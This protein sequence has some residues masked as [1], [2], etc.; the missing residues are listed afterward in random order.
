MRFPRCVSKAVQAAAPHARGILRAGRGEPSGGFATEWVAL[1]IMY[2]FLTTTLLQ[3]YVVPTGSMEGNLRVGDHLLVDRAA[4]QSPGSFGSGM[5]PYRDV[6]RG[7]IIV[8][9]YPEDV[10]KTYVKR[11][12]GLP[13]DRIRIENKQVI[14]NG[15]RLV[16]PYT[17]HID[18]W[19]NAYRDNFPQAPD[20]ETSPRGL[21]MLEHHVRNGEVVLPAGAL[22]ALGDNRDNSEDSRYWGFVPRENVVGKPLIVYWSYDAP[23]EDLQ[24][25]TLTHAVD[26]VQHFFDKTRWERTLLIPRS[27]SAQETGAAQ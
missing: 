14:R 18:S 27:H 7:D 15:R 26:L 19:T 17:Q 13:G 21:D 20:P 5:L 24:E 25:W 1:I 9:L 22:F 4:Y 2:L 10:R 16:E 8:F 12:I 11:I 23:T 3:A 6:E